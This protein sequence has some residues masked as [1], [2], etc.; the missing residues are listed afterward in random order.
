MAKVSRNVATSGR[1]QRRAKTHVLTASSDITRPVI[2]RR[3]VEE[4]RPRW[5][6]I[7]A[8]LIVDLLATPV[9]LLAPV[10]VAIA[11][12]SVVG[13]APIPGILD[14]LLPSWATSSDRR[15]LLTAAFLQ[16]VVVLLMQLQQLASYVLHTQVG[17]SLTVAF[18]AKL[19][20]H[21]QRLSLTFH[22][23]RG[24][25]DSLYRIQYD[26][27]AFQHLLDAVIPFVASG[28]MLLGAVLVIARIDWQLAVV[29]AMVCPVFGILVRSYS[30]RVGGRY[31]NLHEVE[32]SALGVVQEVLAAVRVVKA[33]GREQT[34]HDRF[35]K[36]SDEGKRARVRLSLSESKFGM[37]VN[38]T[39]AFGT[40]AVL[41]LGISHVQSDSL[42]LGLL[43][44]VI[45]YLAR[46]Y[47][48]METLS[49]KLGVVQSALA[50]AQRSFSLLDEAPDVKEKLNPRRLKRASGSIL[51]SDVSF[52]YDG[53]TEVLKN[54]SFEVAPGQRVG[55]AGRTGAG[56]TTLIN[57]LTRFYDP[58]KG[59]ILLDGH[60][61]RDYKLAD[62]RE[63]FAIVLQEPVLFSTSVAENI[64]YAR[65]E[66]SMDEVIAATKA[67]N[68]HEFVEAM[69]E[70]YDSV[71]GERGMT[72]SGGERQR[73][74]LARAFLRDAPVLILDEP[75][76]SVDVVTENEIMQAMERL[77]A[78]RTTLMIAH[79]VSTLEY[80]DALIQ[81]YEGEAVVRD[82]RLEDGWASILDL[83]AD[84]FD[85]IAKP[86]RVKT[87]G[88]R[89]DKPRSAKL[90]VRR[91]R[92][93]TVRKS[94]TGKTSTI[95][96]KSAGS[97]NSGSGRASKTRKTKG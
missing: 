38:L 27:L 33:F 88:T 36:R 32:S 26:A 42:K 19:F 81:L 1:R 34:E 62:L 35:V 48:P 74:S 31:V 25:A 79:R 6:A 52:S 75:T 28:V 96:R 97:T 40:A 11:V 95:R 8:V 51:F 55:I 94:T 29:A 80:C 92:V 93:K 78:G 86:N 17:E 64:A 37:A 12:D 53:A 44:V 61:L 22:D 82:E 65:P 4:V 2:L 85:E 67:A 70:G 23:S 47:G 24:T 30:K 60:D 20:R 3:I 72:L 87:N 46:L 90:T 66:A 43:W 89:S 9:F 59:T 16:V 76:S 63:Q 5:K 10:P 21:T 83:G 54:V 71:V 39:T 73:I 77:M 69:P 14:D 91:R 84:L 57:L 45:G 7:T 49:T 58:T 15:L 13:S 18:K 68:A 56:K 41:L 50:G